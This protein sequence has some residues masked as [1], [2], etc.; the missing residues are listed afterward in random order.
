MNKQ[1]LV[2]ADEARGT[3]TAMAALRAV[4]ARSYDV[5]SR[6]RFARTVIALYE[7]IEGRT[8]PPTDAEIDAHAA[9]GG[10]WMVRWIAGTPAQRAVGDEFGTFHDPRDARKW[11]D[12]R[13][14]YRWIALDRDGRPCAWPEVRT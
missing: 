2:S 13:E 10:G 5:G 3:L 6:E 11:R 12:D 4:G 7:I 1:E 8:A 14:V 9:A